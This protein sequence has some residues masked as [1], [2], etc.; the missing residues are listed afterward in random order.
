MKK[1]L[2]VSLTFGLLLSGCNDEDSL[3]TSEGTGVRFTSYMVESRATDTAWEAGDEIG[4]YMQADAASGY[5]KINVKY[6]NSD[7]NLNTF[8]SETPIEYSG[9]ESTVNFMAV[10]PFSSLVTDGTYEFTLGNTSLSQND[11]MYASTTSV[12]AGTQNVTLNF[13]HKLTK[14]VLQLNDEDG[15]PVTGAT[16]SINKQHASGTLDV[17]TGTIT[18]TSDYTSTLN[19]S[20]SNGTYEAIVIP[21]EG[22]EGRSVLIEAN[23]KKYSYPVGDIAFSGA[24]KYTFPVSLRPAE[25]GEEEGGETIIKL[26]AVKFSI[27]DW[28]EG[29]TIGWIISTG[30]EI[31]TENKVETEL[32]TNRTLNENSSVTIAPKSDMT[33]G[34]TDVYSIEYT[35]TD[36]VLT[37]ATLIIS[38][39]NTAESRAAQQ[40]YTLP[41]GLANGRLLFAVGEF[42]N[43]FSVSSTVTLTLNAV[44]VYSTSVP[45]PEE[46]E[47]PSDTEEEVTVWTGSH[48]LGSWNNG[49]SIDYSNADLLAKTT[50]GCTLRFYYTGWTEGAQLQFA[51]QNTIDVTDDTRYVD[52][53]VTAEIIAAIAKAGNWPYVNGQNLTVTRIALIPANSSGSDNPGGETPSQTE[54]IEVW[55]GSQNLGSWNNGV[56]IDYS[57]ADLLAKT[58]EG[59]TL[60]FYYT[61][62]TEGA[63]LQFAGQN[64][65]DVTDDTRYVDIEVTAE[66]IAAIAEASNWPYVNGQNLTV[67]KIVLICPAGN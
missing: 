35:R 43:G 42:T 22:C 9:N 8:T 4:V 28:T 47:T 38:Q 53:E 39:P 46:P 24:T 58:T 30:A 57:N 59:C 12:A 27:D 44:S 40:T 37:V 51:G 11:I 5:Q 52:I 49:V 61:G 2:L 50:E 15:N 31:S 18:A 60:R 67:T 54:E 34:K 23:G 26:D 7:G 48:K 16:I 66:I 36:A 41:A 55:T 3:G 13:Q 21:D 29:K 10:Y 17:A 25:P 56:S 64:T 65:I 33:L 19:F 63:Q 6:A 62:W 32:M 20:E 45:T 14:I 1:T